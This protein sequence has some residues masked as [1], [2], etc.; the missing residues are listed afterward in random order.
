MSL[1]HEY[2]TRELH[3]DAV[4]AFRNELCPNGGIRIEWSGPIGFGQYD[5]VIGDDGKI[6]GYSEHMEKTEDK[7]FSKEL[8]RLL[9]EMIVV[10]E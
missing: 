5:L 8:F 3:I 10:E 9:H 1:T 6:R 7:Y 4:S 2:I